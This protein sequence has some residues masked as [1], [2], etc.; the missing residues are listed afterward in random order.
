M[1]IVTGSIVIVA[2]LVIAASSAMVSWDDQPTAQQPAGCCPGKPMSARA[3]EG[4]CAGTPCQAFAS[5][6]ADDERGC[7]PKKSC[8]DTQTQ[9]VGA[10]PEGPCGSSC[11]HGPCSVA[12]QGC[13]AVDE[14]VMSSTE[15][16]EGQACEKSCATADQEEDA[17][18]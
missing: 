1:K 10:A 9:M 16:A 17:A 7:C 3:A 6:Q 5:K 15:E 2:G 8:G 11:A 4:G 12:G 13:G 14:P 18:L